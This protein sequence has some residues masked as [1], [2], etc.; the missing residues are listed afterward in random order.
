MMK[1]HFSLSALLLATMLL[2]LSPASSFAAPNVSPTAVAPPFTGISIQGVASEGNGYV[3][4]NAP[5]SGTKGAIAIR[6]DGTIRSGS[7]ELLNQNGVVVA[8]GQFAPPKYITDGSGTVV[9]TIYYRGFSLSSF[10]SGGIRVRA[11]NYT[12]P[13]L[14]R[15]ADTII[16]VIK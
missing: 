2:L 12:T 4:N 7:L 16:T 6:V 15:S 13:Y 1:K 3:F 11:E 8:T 10:K 5:L 14:S 9:S